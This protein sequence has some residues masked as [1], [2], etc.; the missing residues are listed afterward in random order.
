MALY[1]RLWRLTDW[2]GGG[3]QAMGTLSSLHA[4]EKII[5]GGLF[6]QLGFFAFFIVVAAMFHYRFVNDKPLRRHINRS[7]HF[8]NGRKHRQLASTSSAAATATLSHAE[9]DTL[10]W[11]RHLYNLYIAST[12]IIVRSVFRVIEYLQ[13]NSGYLLSHEVF[14]YLF[15]ALLML[16]VMVLFIGVH[17]SEITDS[18]QKRHVDISASELQR[19]RDGYMVQDGEA[20][21]A[22]KFSG[23]VRS[24]GA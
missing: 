18:Y 24:N 21:N 16:A 13:G 2:I 6:V 1:S 12:L 11:K 14:L 19:V 23:T 20:G 4:G 7:A 22:N 5:I 3:I 10:P 17:P 9:I 8:G 15:D